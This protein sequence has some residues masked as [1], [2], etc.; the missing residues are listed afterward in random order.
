MRALWTA[1]HGSSG[2][3]SVSRPS[4]TGVDESLA[5]RPAVLPALLLQAQP[6]EVRPVDDVLVEEVEHF[7]RIRIQVESADPGYQGVD[8]VQVVRIAENDL[9]ETSKPVLLYFSAS[10]T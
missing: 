7:D 5:C 4:R 3:V 6:L 1:L 10:S 2:A 8:V 9:I